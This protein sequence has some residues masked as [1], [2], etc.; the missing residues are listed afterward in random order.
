MHVKFYTRLS[1]QIVSKL[2]DL[3][4]YLVTLEYI[5]R[6]HLYLDAHATFVIY[7]GTHRRVNHRQTINYV[8][9]YV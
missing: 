7:L 5:L 2:N 4:G 1:L 3:H 8:R 6:L 9:R